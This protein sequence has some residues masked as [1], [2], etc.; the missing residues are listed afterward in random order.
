MDASKVTAASLKALE[1]D[2]CLVIPGL[3][4]KLGVLVGRL[5]WI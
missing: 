1:R 5:G 2:Q 4:Y 3:I